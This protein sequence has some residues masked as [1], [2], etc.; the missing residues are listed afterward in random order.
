MSRYPNVLPSPPLRQPTDIHA[1]GLS[2]RVRAIHC[3]DIES[4]TRL[5]QNAMP[6][7]AGQSKQGLQERLLRVFLQHPWIDD[8][9]R[10]LVYEDKDGNVIGCVGVLPRPMIFENRRITAAISHSFIVARERRASMAALLMAQ[11]FFSGPQ[12]VSIAEGNNASRTIWERNGG[13][14]SLL[15]SLCWTRPL[16]PGRYVLSFLR[17]RGMP[18]MLNSLLN[19]IFR[20]TDACSPLLSRRLFG[21]VATTLHATILDVGSMSEILAECCASRI[22]RPVY[23]LTTLQW[24]LDTL[25][26]KTERGALHKLRVC[27]SNGATVGWYLYYA[28]PGSVGIVVQMGARDGY[29]EEVL[30]HLFAHA[31]KAGCV[32]VSGQVDPAHFHAYSRNYCLFHHDGASWVLTH[33][34]NPMLQQSIDRGSAYITR[35]EG[36]WWIGSLLNPG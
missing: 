30:K 11:Y 1:T 33:S 35:L 31:S 4:I 2:G 20:L 27:E 36:E 24:L 32:A 10:S 28:K 19:P 13:S 26:F 21:Q 34:R 16:R 17:K 29:A 23:N 9:L 3:N 5:Y 15:H 18:A 6:A 7:L 12:E 14:T 22:L 8:R 25:A